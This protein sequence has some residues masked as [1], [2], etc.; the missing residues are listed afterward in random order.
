M[1]VRISLVLACCL[2]LG[3]ASSVP[4][5]AAAS[6][7]VR[8]P[9]AASEALPGLDLA[10]RFAAAYGGF[11][12]LEL[13]E[14]DY[15]R[16]L[17]SGLP[18]TEDAE[19]GSV[20]IVRYRFDP[21]VDG[22]PALGPGEA[23]NDDGPGF[24]LVQFR[25]PVTAAW[26]GELAAA[27]LE[28]LQ[29]YPHHAYLVWGAPAATEAAATLPFVRWQ[30]R[31]HPAYKPALELDGRTGI[32][33]NVDV[34]FYGEDLVEATLNTIS[35]SSAARCCSTTRRSPTGSS[36]TRW[37][38]CRPRRSPRWPRSRTSSG[39]ASSGRARSSTTR[40]RRRSWPATI[41]EV[42]RRPATSPS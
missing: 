19:A 26:L 28:P 27:G 31:V 24:H 12:W 40:C 38:R 16:L 4:A 37:S 18:F 8:L 32:V 25:G 21:L 1:R 20:Q 10:P 15:R 29:Y 30:G 35:R 41:P 3:A 22:E 34:L 5:A 7:F 2:L 33:R 23:A 36:S 42:F 6:R 13:D 11:R 17:A 14:D 9:A 39:S